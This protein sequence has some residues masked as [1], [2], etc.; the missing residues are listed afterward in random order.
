MKKL[1]LTLIIF[2]LTLASCTSTPEAPSENAIQTA[3]A[4]TQTVQV[5]LLNEINL[6]SIPFQPGDLPNQYKS[7]QASYKWADDLPKSVEPDNV[8]IQ[9]VGW[10][11]SS[12]FEDDYVMIALFKSKQDLDN[13]FS[14]AINTYRAEKKESSTVGEQNAFV[15]VSAFSGDG[16]LAFTRCSALVVIRITGADISEELLTSYAQRID[17]RLKPLICQP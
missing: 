8:V 16:F 14:A 10:D 5:A 12:G 9:K 15:M 11:I 1:F 6:D 4:Q 7:G 2:L 3:I 13:S 17:K